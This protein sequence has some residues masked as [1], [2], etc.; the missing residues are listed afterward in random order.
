MDEARRAV[1]TCGMRLFKAM[2]SRKPWSSWPTGHS[3]FRRAHRCANHW[4]Q[5]YHWM[6][7]GARFC[8]DRKEAVLNV[9]KPWWSTNRASITVVRNPIGSSSSYRDGCGFDPRMRTPKSTYGLVG[10]SE[11]AK[12]PA[13]HSHQQCTRAGTKS[14][15][16]PIAQNGHAR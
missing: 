10:M 8:H 5:T 11:R 4:H 13:V 2:G 14:C 3:H 16:C 15:D 12:R 6:R 1:W 9:S 7:G